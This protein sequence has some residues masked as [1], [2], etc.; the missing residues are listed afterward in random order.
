[1]TETHLPEGFDWTEFVLAHG[2]RSR[3]HELAA[4]VGRPT[5]D[6]QRL[7]N[8]GACRRQRKAKSFSEL[9]SLCHGRAPEEEEWPLPRKWGARGRYEWQPPEVALLASLVGRLSAADIARTLTARLRER[10]GDLSA[11]RSRQAVQVRV[12]LIGLQISKDVI[13]G[14]T[15]AE[16]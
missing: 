7:R 1:M 6:V 2:G 5:E 12:N 8:T 10:T 9:F 4:V 14:V 16:A 13:G 11:E 15:T 3:V